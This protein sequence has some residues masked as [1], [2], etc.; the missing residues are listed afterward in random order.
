MF[1]AGVC[2]DGCVE[3]HRLLRAAAAPSKPPRSLPALA[4][5]TSRTCAEVQNAGDSL[6]FVNP[7]E[8]SVALEVFCG[9]YWNAGTAGGSLV[10]ADV[11]SKQRQRLRVQSSLSK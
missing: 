2:A 6:K 7:R 9:C 8:G 5:E 1:T 11:N 4:D 3:Q 10:S